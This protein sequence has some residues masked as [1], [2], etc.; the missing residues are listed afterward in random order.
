MDLTNKPPVPDY[1]T[2]HQL[3]AEH[4]DQSPS[5]LVDSPTQESITLL[6]DK[7]FDE[8]I[9]R[10][11][12]AKIFAVIDQWNAAQPI[13]KLPLE[14]IANIVTLGFPITHYFEDVGECCH[15]ATSEL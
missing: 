14:L 12:A 1:T 6:R 2:F 4:F 13:S 9:P 8:P 3:C 7:F 11:S 10:S 15:V 5:A